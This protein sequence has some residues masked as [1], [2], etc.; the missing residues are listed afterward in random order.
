MNV[1]VC[2][3][4]YAYLCPALQELWKHSIVQYVQ[5]PIEVGIVIIIIILILQMMK[6]RL[7][8]NK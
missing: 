3:A 2:N 8:E 1:Y 6:L 7:R 4:H 5:Q